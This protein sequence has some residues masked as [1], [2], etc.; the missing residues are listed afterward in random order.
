MVSLAQEEPADRGDVERL[1]ELC[2]GPGRFA[3]TAY[4]FRERAEPMSALSL[5]ARG[6]GGIDGSLRFWPISVGPSRG[7][8]L[9]P[10]AVNPMMRG[11][12]IGI[13]LMI[14][15]LSG[16]RRAA[17]PWVMLVGDEPYYARVGFRQASPSQFRLP[18]P[19]DPKRLLI[20]EI[21]PGSLDHCS[22]TVVATVAPLMAS[23]AL[24]IPGG[25][26]EQ[27]H[28]NKLKG[29]RQ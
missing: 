19:V 5:V 13:G 27:R 23:A 25:G 29:G 15:G 28:E 1:V 21:I 26:E 6:A 9:G 11:Q 3:K 22:G 7:L 12:G 4:R 20:R 17:F 24:A 14:M 18:G 16:A 10:L 2:F 8:L